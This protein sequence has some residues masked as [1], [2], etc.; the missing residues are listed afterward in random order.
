MIK[1]II[2]R[3]KDK[4]PTDGQAKNKQKII[5]WK[6]FLC[7]LSLPY[8][9]NNVNSN[10]EWLTWI[11]ANHHLLSYL[12]YTHILFI[13]KLLVSSIYKSK[14][15]NCIR[16]RLEGSLFISSNNEE[17]KR[18]LRLNL[19]LIYPKMLSVKPG[20]IKFHLWSLWSDSTWDWTPAN[21]RSNIRQ[22]PR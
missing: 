3:N 11:M 17:K 14:V 6:M 4:N 9:G 20:G 5:N 13:Y 21:T 10:I 18:A 19:S 7:L 15:G 12:L 22:Y 8:N 16:R 1:K 2:K